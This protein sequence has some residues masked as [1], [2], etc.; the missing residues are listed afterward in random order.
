MIAAPLLLG[1]VPRWAIGVLL[2]L[3]LALAV[4]LLTVPALK[5][6]SVPWFGLV[7]CATALFIGLQALPVPGVVA[8]LLSPHAEEVYRDSLVPRDMLRFHPLS[9]DG[10]ATGVELAKGLICAVIFATAFVVGRRGERSRRRLCM[11]LVGAGVLVAL[12]GYCHRLAN[13]DRLFGFYRYRDVTPTFL[14]TLANKNNLAGLF[15][16]CAPPALALALTASERRRAVLWGVCYVLLGAGTFLTLSR[17]GMAAFVV[18]Q[19]LLVV[20][21]PNS[22]TSLGIRAALT[23]G[24]FLVAAYLALGEISGRL[25]TLAPDSVGKEFKFQGM[26]QS[27]GVLKDYPLVGIGRGAFPTAGARYLDVPLGTAEYVENET[28]QPLLDLGWFMG[29]LLLLSALLL[30]IRATWPRRGSGTERSPLA[31][32]LAAGVASLFAQNQVDFSLEIAGVAVPAMVAFGLLAAD[33]RDTERRA[34]TGRG[35][36]KAR[37]VGA[38]ALVLALPAAL[39]L[40]N[41]RHDWRFEVDSFAR[42]ARQAPDF[43][44]LL[45]EAEP[46]LFSH[47]ASFVLP[48]AIADRALREQPPQ[49]G[50]ALALGYVNRALTLKPS[51]P[52]GHLVAAEALALLGRKGQSLLEA[53]L[54][55]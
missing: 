21:L 1:S 27:T 28:L 47:P 18:G 39:G 38:F 40:W 44:Q 15:C 26:L 23:A 22:A 10:P 7:L 29:A 6:R 36:V 45:S 13:L 30:W 8:Q 32:G 17:G 25:M 14:T 19:L 16:L 48:L 55:F 46:L 53:R 41:G 3:S 50:A 9:I 4:G 51:S 49:R 34:T 52:E 2:V 43:P 24:A 5:D 33:G 35:S 31:A 12:I 20:L 37:V 42:K 54:Y 11:A